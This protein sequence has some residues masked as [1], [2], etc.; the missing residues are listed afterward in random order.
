MP[1]VS[2]RSSPPIGHCR[3]T[4]GRRRR[5]PI[6]AAPR[7]KI[8]GVRVL[9]TWNPSGRQQEADALFERCATPHTR[10]CARL[11][12]VREAVRASRGWPLDK[13][14]AIGQDR[15]Q[16][17]PS[18]SPASDDNIHQLLFVGEVHRVVARSSNPQSSPCRAVMQQHA[19]AIVVGRWKGS[20][21]A[22]MEIGTDR[23]IGGVESGEIDERGHQQHRTT[24]TSR[25]F[26]QAKARSPRRHRRRRAAKPASSS[27]QGR[28]GQRGPR[29]HAHIRRVNECATTAPPPRGRWHRRGS[30]TAL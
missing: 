29:G 18:R 6:L 13:A 25:R 26:R 27:R 2:A 7:R 23:E 24:L 22:E 20:R 30:S 15:H 8:G 21:C 28:S 16:D 1:A 12:A 17:S 14:V 5:L 3:F 10:P 9:I 4:N 11:A 19:T